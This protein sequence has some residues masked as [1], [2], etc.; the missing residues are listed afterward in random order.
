MYLKE[1]V[2]LVLQENIFQK[3]RSEPIFLK[4]SVVVPQICT[5]KKFGNYKNRQEESYWR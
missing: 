2:D 5:F 4:K 1:E 3:S